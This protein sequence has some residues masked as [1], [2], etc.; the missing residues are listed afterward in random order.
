[1][2]TTKWFRKS[3]LRHR[4]DFKA[5]CIPV[6]LFGDAVAVTGLGKSWGKSLVSITLSGLINREASVL[7][8][9]L[10]LL[11]WKKSCCEDTLPKAWRVIRWSLQAAYEG[12][13]PAV[14]WE[15]LCQQEPAHNTKF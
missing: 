9:M 2:Q 5:K 15:G 4:V 3:P 10:L 11:V 12:V 7:S 14:D 8:Q 13:F 1:M 6:K